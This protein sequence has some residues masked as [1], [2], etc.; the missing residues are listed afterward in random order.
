V[1]SVLDGWLPLYIL[2]MLVEE[3]LAADPPLADTLPD[4]EMVKCCGGCQRTH[5]PPSR[6]EKMTGA[7]VKW[8]RLVAADA[9]VPCDHWISW[10]CLEASCTGSGSVDHC[11][12]EEV[13]RCPK[14]NALIGGY[15]AMD[16]AGHML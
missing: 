5:A 2:D 4:R 3:L 15:W 7:S 6:D 11:V 13:L 16:A 14:C 9:N 1:Y 12:D 8:A 10:G